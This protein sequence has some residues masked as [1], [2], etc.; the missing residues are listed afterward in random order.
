M[1]RNES[2][3]ARDFREVFDGPTGRRVLAH[4]MAQAGMYVP[5]SSLEP[6]ALAFRAGQQNIALMIAT[7]LAYKPSEFVERARE[8]NEDL[9]HYE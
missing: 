6:Q 2:R 9:T 3:I 5:P 4:I 1:A 7:Y 8:H